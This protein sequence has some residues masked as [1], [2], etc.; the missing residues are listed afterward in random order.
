MSAKSPTVLSPEERLL[1]TT[2][3]DDLSIEE[4]TK[5]YA[6]SQEDIQFVQQH[7]GAVNRLGVALQLCTLRYPGRF[8]IQMTS[9]SES[10]LLYVAEQLS[11][12]AETF[13]Q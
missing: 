9:I 2:I 3:P 4:M 1:F 5:Y 7:R 11:L 10:V 6:L 8:L 12:S 13:N